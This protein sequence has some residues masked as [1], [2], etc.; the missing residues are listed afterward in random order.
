MSKKPVS[1][2]AL[3]SSAITIYRQSFGN[4]RMQTADAFRNHL[5]YQIRLFGITGR[6]TGDLAV[7]RISRVFFLSIKRSVDDPQA[8]QF[9]G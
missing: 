7:R 1:H 5:R 8:G 3:T 2:R 4:S 9:F 6:K